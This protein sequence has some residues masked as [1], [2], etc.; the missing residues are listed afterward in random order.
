MDLEATPSEHLLLRP[1][2]IRLLMLYVYKYMECYWKKL[3]PKYT[4]VQ[5][6]TRKATI[7][8]DVIQAHKAN[9]KK[10]AYFSFFSVV[11]ALLQSAFTLGAI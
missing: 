2:L 10:P 8:C 11:K 7:N 3:T 4:L 5:R 9:A 6:N 1:L